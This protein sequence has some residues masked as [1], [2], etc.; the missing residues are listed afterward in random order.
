MSFA[1]FS[2]GA[3][4]PR[5]HGLNPKGFI[6]SGGPNSVYEPGGAG[7]AGLFLE[8]GLPVLGICYGMQLLAH[9]LGGGWPAARSVNMA[10]PSCSGCSGQPPVCRLASTGRRAAARPG[11]DEPRRQGGA[12]AGR[13]SSRWPIPKFTACGRGRRGAQLLRRAVSPGSGAHAAG[14]RILSNFVHQ[15]CGC[16]ADWTPAQL[17]R[18]SRSRRS[19]SRWAT[20]R[21]CWV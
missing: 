3:R 1:S 7:A 15:I 18:G 16:R 8:S 9:R 6:L 13:V 21:S 14:R 2:P 19:G 10:R 11:L 12:A 20:A 4:R 17:H 5:C